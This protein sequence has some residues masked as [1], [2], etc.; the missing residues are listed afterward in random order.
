[1]NETNSTT[2]AQQAARAAVE[3]L[4]L[5]GA[6]GLT[7]RA[8]DQHA[9]L[10]QGTTSNYFR[11]RA[12]LINAICGFLTEHDLAALDAASGTLPIDHQLSVEAAVAGI[13]KIIETWTRTEAIF[14]AARLEL[15]LIA[16]RDLEV[17]SHLSEVRRKFRAKVQAWIESLAPGTG[18]NA[19]AVMALVEGITANQLLHAEGRM[20]Q[21]EISNAIERFLASLST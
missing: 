21:A 14:T 16:L 1:M 3:V 2:R 6:S 13:T 11:T 7:H 8:V 19:P 17:A 12:A 10:P 20:S 4:G 9:G 15:F 5:Y 18:A